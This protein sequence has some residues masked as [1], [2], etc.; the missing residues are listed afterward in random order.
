MTGLL[1]SLLAGW[2]V[3]R[4]GPAFEK[5]REDRRDFPSA[6]ARESPRAEPCPVCRRTTCRTFARP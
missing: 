5:P 2:W 6:R 1:I 4:T 3:A